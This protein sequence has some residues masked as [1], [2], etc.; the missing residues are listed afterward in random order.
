MIARNFGD[1]GPQ[2]IQ[3]LIVSAACETTTLEF[4]RDL[5]GNGD[6]AKKEFLADVSALAN[7]SGGDLLF[8]IDEED[9][10][11]ASIVGIGTTETDSELLR[12]GNILSTGLEPR[13]RHSAKVV[14]C[15]TGS[16]LVL[17]VE[18]S[19]NAPHRVVFKA[20]D[21]FYGR[22]GTR[23][24]PLDVQQLRSAFVENATV[25]DRM[26]NFRAERLASIIGGASFL[27]TP[28]NPKFVLHLLP[29]EAFFSTPQHDLRQG[30]PVDALRPLTG[31]GWHTRLTFEGQMAYS[32]SRD[33]SLS[34]SYLHFYRT[35]VI[36]MVDASL[37]SYTLPE[38]NQRYVPGIGFERLMITGVQRGLQLLRQVGA[39]AP[40]AVA[41]TLTDVKGMILGLDDAWRYDVT[42]HPILNDHLFLPDSVLPQLDGPVDPIVRPLADLVWNACGMPQSLHFDEAGTWTQTRR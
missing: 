19:W 29:L 32:P 17:R 23:K 31:G 10:C 25:A 40:V 21:R 18:K 6:E 5:P 36:E 38:S 28:P 7:T 33:G 15:E 37:L 16:V 26:R 20:L 24:Y 2:D 41:I 14:T 12:L 30:L 3:A 13:I 35:G 9:G 39:N 27:P 22:S 1:I 42:A 34:T 11:A 8:G 4:K